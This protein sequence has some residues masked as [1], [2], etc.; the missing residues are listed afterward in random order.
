MME[1][2][3][4]AGVAK[5]TSIAR[6]ALVGLQHNPG[7]AFQVFDLLSKHNINVDVIL[8]SIGREE[9]KDIT[10]T[11]HKKD[12]EEAET[13]L[14]EHRAALRFDHRPMI[15]LAKSPSSALV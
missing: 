1:K 6:I 5:D 9:T 13:I 11:I 8:Q 2:T 4:I 12:Q 3:N 7:V 15:K 14:N 10:F